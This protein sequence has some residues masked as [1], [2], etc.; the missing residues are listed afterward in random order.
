M[1]ARSQPSCIG[2]DDHEIGVAAA[3]QIRQQHGAGVDVVDRDVEEALDLIGVQIHRQHTFHAHGLEQVGHDLGADGHAGAARPAVLPGVAEVGDHGGDAARAG[4]LERID[5]DQQ[6]HQVFI[7]GVAGA[8]H[9]E[10]VAGA[11]VLLDLD[12]DLAVAEAAHV[13]GTDLDAQVGGDFLGQ[14][15]VGVAG[16]Q[17]GVEQHGGALLNRVGCVGGRWQDQVRSFGRGGR[18][19]TL[20]CRNQN[21]MP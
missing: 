6:L 10:D 3:A 13:R 15:R 8:L 11:H 21:P 12:R 18:T 16:E 20:A 7:G 2:R 4:A 17:H 14:H 9:D 1:M 5:H 19:R